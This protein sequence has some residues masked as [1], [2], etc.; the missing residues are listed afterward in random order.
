MELSIPQMQFISKSKMKLRFDSPISCFFVIIGGKYL[1]KIGDVME[2]VDSAS[3]DLGGIR[4]LAVFII[5][6]TNKDNIDININY[7]FDRFRSTPVMVKL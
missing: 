5:S 2:K 7:G 1:S 3:D 4:P 6:N